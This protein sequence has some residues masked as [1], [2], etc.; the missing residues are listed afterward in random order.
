MEQ[1]PIPPSNTSLF[2]LNL[3]AGNSASLRGAA[4]WAKLLAVCGFII[5]ILFIVLGIFIQNVLSNYSGSNQFNDESGTTI[6]TARAMGMLMYI[7]FG[8]LYIVS[9]IFAFNFGNRIS[10]ALRTNDQDTL[11][12]GFAAARNYFAFWAILMIITLLLFLITM[13]GI[14]AGSAR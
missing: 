5:G 9:S 1:S 2:Q 3:D 12:S 11:S 13:L 14:L 7:M 10:R 6:R 4:S 8:L